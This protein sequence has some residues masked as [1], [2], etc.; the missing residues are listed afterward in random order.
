MDVIHDQFVEEQR[1][2]EGR[3]LEILDAVRVKDSERLAGYHLRS[4]KFT[5]FNDV[6]PMQRLDIDENNRLEREELAEFDNI[7]GTIDGLKVDVFGPVAVATGLL[8]FTFDADGE[9]ESDTVRMTLVLANDGGDWKIAHEHF[10]ALHAT[11]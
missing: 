1:R 5:K 2:V 6:E 3:L 8:E 10:S 4:P 9:R 7:E 11:G